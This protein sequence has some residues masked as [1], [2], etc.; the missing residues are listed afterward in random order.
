MTTP[1]D[2]G[3]TLSDD[4]APDPVTAD[5]A[6]TAERDASLVAALQQVCP[7][8]FVVVAVD[9]LRDVIEAIR[10]CRNVLAVGEWPDLDQATIDTI[11]RWKAAIGEQG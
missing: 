10:H 4:W 6:T 5:F 9:D 3:D 7:D 1:I 11:F 8:W 2:P